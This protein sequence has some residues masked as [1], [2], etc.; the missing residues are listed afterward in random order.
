MADTPRTMT[1]SFTRAATVGSFRRAFRS[2]PTWAA[3]SIGLLLLAWEAY[4]RVSG[5]RLIPP[6]SKVLVAMDRLIQDGSLQDALLTSVQALAIG[7]SLALVIGLAMGIAMASSEDVEDILRPYINALLSVPSVAYIVLL[8]LWF[9]VGLT[10]RVAIVFE[11]AVLLI[12]VNT[13]VGVKGVDESLREMGRSFGLSRRLMIWGIVIPAALPAIIAGVRL[14][15]GRAVKG[16]VNSE[17]LL[18]LVGLGGLIKYY[19]ASFRT[20]FLLALVLAVVI[21]AI[22][23]VGGLQLVERRLNRWRP[24]S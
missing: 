5:G 21:L 11:Y 6:L 16:M 22:F 7:F 14:G 24:A 4:G 18:A 13:L 2:R 8:L 12:A 23:L 17:M 9:G 15:L 19:G 1:A 10:A 3:A 20:D